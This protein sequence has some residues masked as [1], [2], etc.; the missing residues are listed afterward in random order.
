MQKHCYICCVLQKQVVLVNK[1][2]S[3]HS[4]DEVMA[5]QHFIDGLKRKI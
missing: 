3:G 5:R 2:Y 1:S 4:L